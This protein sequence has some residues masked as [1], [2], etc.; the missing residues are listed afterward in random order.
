MTR[1]AFD[2][3]AQARRHAGIGQLLLGVAMP[4]AVG[5]VLWRIASPAPALI[6]ALAG[7]A[8]LAAL[9]WRRS[10]AFDTAWL[11]RQLDAQRRDLDD[12]SDLLLAPPATLTPLQH[13]QQARIRERLR[14]QPAPDL[15]A[16]WP[17]PRIVAMWL[18]A[19]VV[20][21]AAALWPAR[22]SDPGTLAPADEDT[23]VVPGVPRL[24]A[25]R[26]HVAPPAY[27][28]QSPRDEATLD[29]KAPA[30][31]RLAW[32]LRFVPQPTR[33]DLVFHDGQRIALVRDGDIW[34]ATHVLVK[35]TLY[36]VVA[37]GTETQPPAKLRRL[38]AVPDRVPQVKVLAPDRGLSL[39]A[40]GQTRWAL[41]FE[42]RDDY[43]VASKA[44]LKLTLAQGSGENIAFKEQVMTLHGT[45]PATARRFAAS[46]DLKAL[47][48]AVG[49]DLIAQ[50]TVHDTR[51]PS[52]QTAQSPGLILRW[53][54]DLG[55]E[56]TG[57]EGL[58][59]KV[60]PAYFRS[61]RQIIIDAE[62]LQK[63]KRGL[64][65]DTFVTRSDGIG[66]DQR[67]LRLRYGQFLGEEAEGEPQPPP[68]S[69]TDDDHADDDGHD[70]ASE[71]PAAQDDHD[72]AT[73][74]TGT[75]FGREA[76]VLEAYGHTHDH[77]EAATLLDPETRA[78]LK[79]ALD[80]MWQS[81]LHLRQGQPDRALPFAYKALEYIKQVQQA[82]RIYLARVGPELPP[83]DETRRMGGDRKGIASRALG[84][85]APMPDDADAA[86][87]RAWRALADDGAPADVADLDAL[88]A[89]LH[90]NE[91]RVPDALDLFAAIDEVR[92]DPACASC[93][94]RLRA[95]LWSASPQPP[96]RVPR[97]SAPDDAG[98][99][100][101]DALQQE[102]AR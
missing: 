66:V 14:T 30:G 92:G 21:A 50:L 27:T 8:V 51:A 77:A 78:T 53:P 70:H 25:Q 47:G 35:S 6:V 40:V 100:Y 7:I 59:K 32:T 48:M 38:D 90:T 69:D 17:W 39:V 52:P 36:R 41:A 60:M 19:A 88:Q 33:A 24:I 15:R 26:L 42:A 23:P 81:E 11:V 37:A 44:T 96:A 10:R 93:R 5:G 2:R 83:I 101:L 65:A 16:P 4:V 56:S 49:D 95:M 20:V 82:T 9:A 76:D 64:A 73:S 75:G 74:A 102:P 91:A 13:L 28:G 63:Q 87:A 1:S 94:A 43:G 86:P 98:R 80:Q 31:S 84:P 54:A 57:L 72:H 3:L 99:R 61:Q 79:K 45:G 97:R 89:W 29:A 46:L 12:S 85:L 55:Q 68:T 62:A 71:T 34:Q 22:T 67:I 18:A 58:V